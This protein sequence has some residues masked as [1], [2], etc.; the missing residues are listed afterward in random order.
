M[1]ESRGMWVD[2]N[3]LEA[4]ASRSRPRARSGRNSA[5]GG[6]GRSSGARSSRPGVAH[7]GSAAVAELDEAPA[8]LV[9]VDEAEDAILKDMRYSAWMTLKVYFSEQVHPRCGQRGCCGSVAK[10]RNART[11]LPRLPSG[12]I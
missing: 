8:L 3:A 11:L 12:S 2:P 1:A 9:E 5:G 7:G 6:G 10:S 4:K